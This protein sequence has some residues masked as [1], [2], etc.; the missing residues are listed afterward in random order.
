MNQQVTLSTAS[1][2][3]DRHPLPD[4]KVAKATAKAEAVALN[5]PLGENF[6]QPIQ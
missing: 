1:M 2:N 4:T 3:H 5:D 6:E